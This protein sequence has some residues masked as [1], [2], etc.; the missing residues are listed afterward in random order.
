VTPASVITLGRIQLW[1]VTPHLDADVMA[2]RGVLPCNASLRLQD[3]R[4]LRHSLNVQDLVVDYGEDH[5]ASAVAGALDDFATRV[6]RQ[7]SSDTERDVAT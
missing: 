7:Q 1:I 2:P 6:D 5:D 3:L 4:P